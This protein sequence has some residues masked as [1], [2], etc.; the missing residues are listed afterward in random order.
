MVFP[1]IVLGGVKSGVGKT[2]ISLGIMKALTSKG[3]DVQPFKVGPDYIDTSLHRHAAGVYSHNLDSWMGSPQ[4]V[5]TIFTRNA[6]RKRISVIEG[7]MGLFDGCRQGGYEGST[8]HIALLLDAPVILIV[9]VKGMGKSCVPLVK[10]FKDYLSS[11]R[12]SGVIL[13]RASGDFQQRRL[14]EI[15]KKELGVEVFGVLPPT[16]EI[17]FPER[18]LGLVPP[19][20]NENLEKLLE[21]AELLIQSSLDLEKLLDAADKAPSL[22]YN[23]V[24]EKIYLESVKIG[25]AWDEVFNFYYQDSLDYLEELGAELYYFSPLRDER[26]PSVSG[27]YLGGGFPE[28]YLDS[29]SRNTSMKEA[30]WKAV[31]HGMP[32]LAEGGGFMYLAERIKDLQGNCYSGAGLVP[33]QVEMTNKLQSL[34]YIKAAAQKDNLLT[35]REEVLKGHEFHYSRVQWE[36]NYRPAFTL[37][38]GKGFDNRPEGYA[39]GNLLASYLHIHLRSNP[40]AA[41]N[42]VKACRKFSKKGIEI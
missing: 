33:S 4:V 27:L 16:D 22:N 37:T 35:A 32:I 36:A 30:L 29:L 14:P 39:H 38:G 13:N 24:E 31:N 1:R 6:A 2:V 11:L 18:Y 8:A 7:V 19:Q 23:E 5:S 17:V 3:F 42:F 12:V 21:S 20:E 26:L 10:G 15:L 28:K 25:V 9:D 40:T 41:D 34:G